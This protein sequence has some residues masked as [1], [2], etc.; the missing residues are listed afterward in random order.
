MAEEKN[1]Y[2]VKE[3]KTLVSEELNKQMRIKHL[4]EQRQEVE[5]QL[6]SLLKEFVQTAPAPTSNPTPA[7][8]SSLSN[9]F[10]TPGGN[11]QQGGKEEKQESI[12]DTKPN[13]TIILNFQ[14]VTIKVQRQLDDL[15]KVVDAS[16]SQKLKDGDYIK[17]KG[18]DILQQG[19]EFKFVI[20]RDADV[21]YDSNALQTWRIIKNR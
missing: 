18:N 11:L 16:E 1:R 4:Q 9:T 17:I 14:D 5:N 3:V 6:N 7:P 10:V 19:R 8:N 15:F 2:S 21:V 12:F 13:E 20:F